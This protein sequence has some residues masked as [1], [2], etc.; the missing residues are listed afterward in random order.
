MPDIINV[1][2]FSPEALFLILYQCGNEHAYAGRKLMGGK[3]PN[4][5]H[6]F[7]FGFLSGDAFSLSLNLD[8]T[9]SVLGGWVWGGGGSF[10]CHLVLLIFLK[11]GRSS[12]SSSEAAG[13]NEV[14]LVAC[15]HL[16]EQSPS[17]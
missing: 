16:E 2:N 10:L 17:C 14:L 8:R 12:C 3:R 6:F 13:I 9:L 7:P 11:H 4:S 15:F 1:G 5:V